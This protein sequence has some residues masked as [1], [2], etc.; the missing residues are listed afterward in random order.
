MT[1]S[2]RG[3]NEFKVEAARVLSEVKTPRACDI[4]GTLRSN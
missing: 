1:L 4:C 3:S 2:T